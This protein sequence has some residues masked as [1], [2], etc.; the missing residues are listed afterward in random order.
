[1]STQAY[2]TYMTKQAD[3]LDAKRLLTSY[4]TKEIA[5]KPAAVGLYGYNTLAEPE[6]DDSLDITTDDMKPSPEV[7]NAL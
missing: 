7:L 3:V 4:I 5:G 2:I 6:A 1:M